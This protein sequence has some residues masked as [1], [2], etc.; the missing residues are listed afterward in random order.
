MR[1][2]PRVD[3]AL[4]TK[5]WN[6]LCGKVGMS[7]AQ[8]HMSALEL[9]HTWGEV[10]RLRGPYG[11]QEDI[12]LQPAQLAGVLSKAITANSQCAANSRDGLLRH[13]RLPSIW[14]DFDAR[15]HPGFLQLIHDLELGYPLRLEGAG[16]LEATLHAA[17][18]ATPPSA[19]SRR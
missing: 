7:D 17:Q 8:Q 19:T 9:F 18:S 6:R 5:D 1:N 16:D 10:L 13:A 12:V 15:F 3:F 11:L 14:A 2:D 4:S